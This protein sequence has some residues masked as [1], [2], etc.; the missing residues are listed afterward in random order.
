[1]TA[2]TQPKL[3]IGSRGSDLALWQARYVASAMGCEP[4][5]LVIKTQGDR[6]QHLSLDKVE[7]KGFFT[8]EIEEALLAG[9]IDIAVHSFKDL[10]I[11]A[12]PG[13]AITAVPVRAP[14][15]DI[16]VSKSKVAQPELLWGLPHAAR[17][18]TSSL[19]R[20]AHLLSRR[21]DLEMV[22]IRGN[23]PTRIQKVL[24]GEVHAVVL[25][26][27]G[28][29]RLGLKEQS[30]Y[31]N[32]IFHPL[33]IEDAC[34]PPAQGALAIQCRSDDQATIDALASL[35]SEQTAV[36]V[37]CERLL[38]SFFGGGC[39]LPLGAYAKHD[40]QELHLLASVDAPDG[41]EKLVAQV[42]GEDSEEI[43]QQ[44][45]KELLAQGAQKYL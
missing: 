21:P 24:S 28:I 1:M 14:V 18:G 19:R 4:E 30:P 43:A 33:P 26:E 42:K 16:I 40:G 15:R 41:S 27:A 25:A 10:P 36:E 34:P 12:P 39:H 38:L 37:H 20:K 2:D 45:R 17:V 44:A 13:L 32:L 8:K 9:T 29:E 35:H 5:I 3:I 22:D 7:G 11:E 31:D 6:I 23:V